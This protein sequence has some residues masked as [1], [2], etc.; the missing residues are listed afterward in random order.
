M[1]RKF[2]PL[3]VAVFLSS[4]L[5]L[6]GCRDDSPSGLFDDY[7]TRIVRVQGAPEVKAAPVSISELPRKRDLRVDIAPVSMGLLDSYQLR[8]CGLFHLI[9]ERNSVLGKVADEFR[10]YD[11][12]RALLAGLTQ[13]QNSLDLDP[14]LKTT[15]AE[16]DNQKRPQLALHQWN[17]VYTSEAMQK[18]LSGSQWLKA[19]MA[20]S[21]QQVNQALSI[22]SSAFKNSNIEVIEAQETLEKKPIV[23]QIN[24]S[25]VSATAGLNRASDQ[26]Y[27]NDHLIICAPNRDTTKFKYLNNVFEQQFVGQVQPYMAQLDSYYQTLSANLSLFDPQPEIHDYVYPLQANHQAFRQAIRRHVS[28]WQ[29]LFKRCGRKVG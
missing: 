4:T 14:E 6:T 26:L 2:S 19:D 16:I 25:L 20:E 7:L 22:V 23:G 28:Y 17:L 8:Q 5:V 11:Y 10:N 1:K 24:Y 15:L 3:K 12:Q 18:Q 21:V 29:Q 27:Q 9:A 13:C